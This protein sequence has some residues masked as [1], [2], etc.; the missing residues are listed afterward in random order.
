MTRKM[1]LGFIVFILANPTF[2]EEDP[3]E[4]VA[5]KSGSFGLFGSKTRFILGGFAQLD[6]IH[7]EKG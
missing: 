2:A 6:L 3:M 4:T 7:G 5:N 1:L